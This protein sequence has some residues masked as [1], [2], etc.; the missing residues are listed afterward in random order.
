VATTPS[1][2]V[3][4]FAKVAGSAMAKTCR[5]VTAKEEGNQRPLG[6]LT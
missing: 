2:G 3:V 5:L 6:A 1:I 4:T